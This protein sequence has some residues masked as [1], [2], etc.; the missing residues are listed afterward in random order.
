MVIA[1]RFCIFNFGDFFD[2]LRNVSHFCGIYVSSEHKTGA[3][4]F[5]SITEIYVSFCK[6]LI[7]REMCFRICTWLM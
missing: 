3:M 6:M 5:P 2:K 7:S 1:C 4:G